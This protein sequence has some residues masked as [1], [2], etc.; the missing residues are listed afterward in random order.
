MKTWIQLPDSILFV[1]PDRCTVIAVAVT[2]C[3]SNDLDS[4]NGGGE[5]LSH[6]GHLLF[7]FGWIKWKPVAHGKLFP[8]RDRSRQHHAIAWLLPFA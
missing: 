7:V 4:C 5:M 6:T 8:G 3:R 2:C 1:L